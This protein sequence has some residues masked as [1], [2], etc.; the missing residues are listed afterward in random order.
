MKRLEQVKNDFTKA[1]NAL[2]Q[3]AL[4][5]KSDLEIDGMIQRFEFTCELLWKFLK[6]YLEHEGIIVKTPREC[7]KE[8]Y[9]MG[10]LTDEEKSLK[11]IDDRNLSVHLYDQKSSRDVFQRIKTDHIILFQEI[12]RRVCTGKE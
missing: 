3:S 9:R 8:A 1:L 10:L 6:L 12:L 5:A 11:M 2:E 7:F 4:E